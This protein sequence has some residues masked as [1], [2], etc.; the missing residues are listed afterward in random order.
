MSIA[1]EFLI[2]S[3]LAFRD[4][5]CLAESRQRVDDCL[6]GQKKIKKEGEKYLPPDKWQK[7]NRKD[8][9][10]Y[11]FRSLFFN[12]TRKTLN[13]YVGMLDMGEPDIT[14][15]NE[16]KM[17]FFRDRSTV[18]G[19]GLKALQRKI[20]IAQLKHG[21]CGLLLESTG[22]NDYPFIIQQYHANDFL[23]TD[24]IT[25]EGESYAKFVLLDESAWVYDMRSKRDI[26]QPRLRVLGLDANGEYYQAGIQLEDWRNFDVDEP[27]DIAIYPD[28]LGKRFDRIPFTWC[29]ASSLSGSSFD[30]PPILNVA[31][32]EISLYQLYADFRQVIYMTGQSPLVISGFKGKNV[33]EIQKELKELIVGSG[34][35]AGLPEGVTAAYLEMAASSLGLI[36]QEVQRLI[37]LCTQ[38]ALSLTQNAN[39]SGVAVQLIQDSNISP[40]Q[41][42]N[43]TAGDAITDQ[44]RYAAKWMGL[45]DDEIKATRY[46]PSRDFAES[47]K[48]IQDLAVIEGSELLTF[49]EKRKIFVENG[50]GDKKKSIEEF[51]DELEEDK[52]RRGDGI[53][54]NVQQ[55]N[56]FQIQQSQKKLKKNVEEKDPE[57]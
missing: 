24:F 10:A 20:N 8:Y 23:R 54:I 16:N 51:F 3:N 56:P 17:A 41:I 38:D 28:Y 57:T 40:L 46:T 21:L 30:E 47:N 11:L 36:A 50:Y 18:Y 6:A 22:N 42:I 9:A 14:F 2:P 31:D 1:K 4:Y 12:F 13:R 32:A 35:I 27:G 48:T 15:G 45:S 25:N 52:T 37:D 55:G 39:Q 26:L 7:K 29:G 49:A 43:S 44:L 33:E 5:P 19:T 53:S 34:A